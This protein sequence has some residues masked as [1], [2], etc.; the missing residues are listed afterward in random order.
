MTSSLASGKSSVMPCLRYRD[1]AR[2][3]E[4]LCRNLGFE[5]HLIV[6]GENGHIVHAQLALGAGMVMLGSADDADSEYGRL[7]RQPEQVDGFETQSPYVVVHDA[8][9]VYRKVREDGGQIVLELQD[10]DYG[11]RSFSFRDPEGH[12]WNVGTYDPW[13]TEP[14]AP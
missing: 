3:I 7:V 9:A 10:E 8:D 5:K 6:P 4:W 13:I 14:G 12:L 11:G 2:A 1:A